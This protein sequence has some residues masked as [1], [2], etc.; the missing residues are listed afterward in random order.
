MNEQ[1]QPETPSEPEEQTNVKGSLNMSFPSDGT[2]KYDA[3][4]QKTLNIELEL[5]LTLS[6]PVIWYGYDD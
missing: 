4:S 6:I 2:I 5:T 1:N 3:T